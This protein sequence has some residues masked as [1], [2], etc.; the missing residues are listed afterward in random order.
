MSPMRTAILN[1][2]SLAPLG[3]VS[4]AFPGGFEWR[5]AAVVMVLLPCEFFWSLQQARHER[6][7]GKVRIDS[8]FFRNRR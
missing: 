5:F 6:K 4:F 1:T 3:L 8:I 2:L 7:Y